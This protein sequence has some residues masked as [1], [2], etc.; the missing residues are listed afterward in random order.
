MASRSCGKLCKVTMQ[1]HVKINRIYLDVILQWR[2]SDVVVTQIIV[3]ST[4]CPA[5]FASKETSKHRITGPYVGAIHWLPMDFIA[6]GQWHRNRFRVMTS[7]WKGMFAKRVAF[8]AEHKTNRICLDKLTTHTRNEAHG[9]NLINGYQERCPVND[10]CEFLCI[11]VCRPPCL[12]WILATPDDWVAKF[13]L[14]D[15]GTSKSTN[16][17]HL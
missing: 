11:V 14:Y 1:S 13:C 16:I 5:A 10:I 9:I 17:L 6:K 2:H 8:M 3:T 4:V 7:A 12:L 15:K